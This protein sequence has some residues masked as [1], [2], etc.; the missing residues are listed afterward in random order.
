MGDRG[1]AHLLD[2]FED[3]EPWLDDRPSIRLEHS[4][5]YPEHL[6]ERTARARMKFGVISH[7]VFFFAEWDSYRENLN[8][9][10]FS[11]AYPLRSFYERFPATALASDSPAT[12]WTD[13]DDPFLSVFAAVNRT[14][15][16]GSAFNP[17][18]ALTVGQALEL[19]SSRAALITTNRGV[20]RIEVGYDADFVILDR[21]PFTVAP[22]ELREVT[23]RRTF[24]RGAD[25]FRR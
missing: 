25:V 1:I 4:A 20:G 21:D 17:D 11:A 10:V 6:I 14:T 8:P 2:L 22:Q 24:M 18:Q 19:V 13:C 7:S 3:E 9:S 12:A 15:Y 23:V 16:D 5:I